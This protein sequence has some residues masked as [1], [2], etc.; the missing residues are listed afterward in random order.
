LRIKKFAVF[1]KEFDP[2]EAELT[3]TRKLRRE[4]MY[5]KYGD[6]AE[7][8]YSGKEIIRV[9]AEFSYADGSKAVVVAD[10]KVRNVPVE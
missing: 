5:G 6:I 8:L 4:Y 9:S 2:D 7:G 1:H 10:V 3:R